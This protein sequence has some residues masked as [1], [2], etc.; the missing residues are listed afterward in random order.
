MLKMFQTMILFSNNK[1]CLQLK[2]MI[3]RFKQIALKIIS[4]ISSMYKIKKN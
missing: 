2:I 1:I 4:E 3:I